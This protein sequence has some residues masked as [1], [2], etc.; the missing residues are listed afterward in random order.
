MRSRAM[1]RPSRPPP[2]A[3]LHSDFRAAV[4]GLAKQVIAE[5][6]RAVEDLRKRS[7]RGAI[8]K[9]ILVGLALIALQ[10]A[11]FVYLSTR[12][13]KVVLQPVPAHRRRVARR[14]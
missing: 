1:M 4:Q 8:H 9:F 2:R 7:K 14:R 6:L 11:L 12:Q 10:A 3:P 5:D 13:E